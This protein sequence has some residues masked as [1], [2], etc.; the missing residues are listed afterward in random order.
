MSEDRNWLS[1]SILCVLFSQQVDLF[2]DLN[3]EVVDD[4][5]CH[6]WTLLCVSNAT[7]VVVDRQNLVDIRHD[8]LR[9]ITL[10]SWHSNFVKNRVL[11]AFLC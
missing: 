7:C 2:E 8:H 5:S 3:L 10:Q 1:F 9:S 4:F 11:Q 6:L